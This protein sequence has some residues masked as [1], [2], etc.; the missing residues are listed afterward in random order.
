MSVDNLDIF[1]DEYGGTCD[2]CKIHMVLINL[3]GEC[4]NEHVLCPDCYDNSLKRSLKRKEGNHENWYHAKDY[5]EPIS[6]ENCL[7]CKSFPPPSYIGSDGDPVWICD[8]CCISHAVWRMGG[9]CVMKHIICP[10]CYDDAIKRKQKSDIYR[11]SDY[12][13][14]LPCEKCPGCKYQEKKKKEKE[15]KITRQKEGEKKRKD[16]EE[17][18][19]LL[20]KK[21]NPILKKSKNLRRYLRLQLEQAFDVKEANFWLDD[22]TDIKKI[23]LE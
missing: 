17:E 1:S 6:E 22:E 19:V 18:L 5:K 14:I 9:T 10:D 13:K 20:S 11:S 3:G 15:M 4:V 21:I 2:K 7:V 12:E 8:S 16:R 23:I